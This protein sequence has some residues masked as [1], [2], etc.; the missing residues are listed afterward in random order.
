MIWFRFYDG[1][2]CTIVVFDSV[3]RLHKW[4]SVSTRWN[5]EC[6]WNFW[7]CGR[8]TVIFHGSRKLWNMC[9]LCELLFFAPHTREFVRTHSCCAEDRAS[10]ILPAMTSSTISADDARYICLVMKRFTILWVSQIAYL[11]SFTFRSIFKNYAIST[12]RLLSYGIQKIS[13]LTALTG[14]RFSS[15]SAIMTYTCWFFGRL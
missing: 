12:D 15:S 11:C 10:S 4:Q 8:K 2:L 6:R 7:S 5:C 14:S 9:Q 3:W 1:L 13:H